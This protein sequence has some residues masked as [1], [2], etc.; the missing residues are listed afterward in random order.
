MLAWPHFPRVNE[1]TPPQAD[2]TLAEGVR[3]ISESGVL[4]KCD[5]GDTR[6]VSKE[7]AR[8]G[9]DFRGVKRRVQALEY[10]SC[11]A[12]AWHPVRSESDW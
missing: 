5:V 3:V 7:E 6:G 12:G 1:R 10:F 8:R 4:N 11:Q 2:M 9:D